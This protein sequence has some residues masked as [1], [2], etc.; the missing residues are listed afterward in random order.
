MTP[1]QMKETLRELMAKYSAARTGWIDYF[2]TPE[3]FDEWFTA[4]V[5]TGEVNA[6]YAN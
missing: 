4:Q 6:N 3:G 5:V 2:G 1:E